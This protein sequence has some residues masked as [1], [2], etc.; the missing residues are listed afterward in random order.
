M[1]SALA[2]IEYVAMSWLAPHDILRAI[3]RAIGGQ[4]VAERTQLAFP[5][6]T[7]LTGLRLTSNSQQ[8]AF[9]IQR[10]HATRVEASP[11]G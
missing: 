9:A 8:A 7:I 11:H 6:T 4:V 5:L 1:N 10:R 2:L 3:E